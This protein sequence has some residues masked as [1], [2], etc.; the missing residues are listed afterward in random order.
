[1]DEVKTLAPV[2]TFQFVHSKAELNMTRTVKL[3]RG[4]KSLSVP[5]S[6]GHYFFFKGILTLWT[7]P[8]QWFPSFL[9]L[10]VR[11]NAFFTIYLHRK[12]II[13]NLSFY[14]LKF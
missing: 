3:D 10:G 4:G 13:N 14:S 7:Y 5:L 12:I 8:V 1:M 11:F 6:Q 2:N 9:V